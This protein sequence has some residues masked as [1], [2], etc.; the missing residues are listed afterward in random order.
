MIFLVVPFLIFIY[1]AIITVIGVV[2]ATVIA[3]KTIYWL[4]GVIFDALNP[5][6]QEIQYLLRKL[7]ELG[8]DECALPFRKDEVKSRLIALGHRF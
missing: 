3:W 4:S 5:N 6:H 2:L 7:E 1:E 8:Y